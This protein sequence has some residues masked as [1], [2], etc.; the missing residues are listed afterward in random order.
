MIV[1]IALP[2]LKSLKLIK[3]YHKHFPTSIDSKKKMKSVW[4]YHFIRV[5]CKIRIRT[6]YTL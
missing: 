1:I 3:I 5:L 4:P 2:G 6:V